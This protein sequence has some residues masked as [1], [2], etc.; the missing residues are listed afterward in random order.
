MKLEK[1][2]FENHVWCY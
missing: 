1:D 2:P